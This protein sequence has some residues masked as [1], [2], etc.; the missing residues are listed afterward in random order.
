MR[1]R[2]VAYRSSRGPL[3]PLSPR[4]R[5]G[6]LPNP[7]TLPGA[8]PGLLNDTGGGQLFAMPLPGVLPNGV[9]PLPTVNTPPVQ[10]LPAVVPVQTPAQPGAVVVTPTSGA[11]PAPATVATATP[12]STSWL[13]QSMIAGIPNKFLILGGL[14]AL[15]LFGGHKK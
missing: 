5:L 11:I 9:L 13:D 12:A 15:F 8:W 10:T 6:L 2:I 1:S 3:V 14:G 7:D 4:V